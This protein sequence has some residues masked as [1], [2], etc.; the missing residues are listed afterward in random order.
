MDQPNAQGAGLMENNKRPHLTPEDEVAVAEL[1][2][3]V[4]A[5]PLGNQFLDAV[6]DDSVQLD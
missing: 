6:P 3:A 2:K 4:D 1:M 5:S